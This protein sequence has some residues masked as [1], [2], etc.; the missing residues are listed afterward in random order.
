MSKISFVRGEFKGYPTMKIVCG[1]RETFVKND[2]WKFIADNWDQFI[3]HKKE[4]VEFAA[5]LRGSPK[6]ETK[7][8]KETKTESPAIQ[9]TS[10]EQL[11]AQAMAQAFANAQIAAPELSVARS[12]TKAKAKTKA[13]ARKTK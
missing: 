1:D 4:I 5:S 6:K 10:I 9:Q 7:T 12:T 13:T 3:A 2:A 11:V 8:A